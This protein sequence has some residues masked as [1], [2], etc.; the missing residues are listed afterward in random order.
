MLMDLDMPCM[1]G[2]EATRAIREIERKNGG[3]L[4]II[5]MTAHPM[6]ARKRP[7]KLPGMDGYLAKPLRASAFV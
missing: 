5:A 6:P 7:A 3:H 2:L 4:P 1:N